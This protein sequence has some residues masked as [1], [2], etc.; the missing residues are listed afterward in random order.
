MQF[1]LIWLFE[2]VGFPVGF[3]GAVFSI[4][5]ASMLLNYISKLISEWMIKVINLKIK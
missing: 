5:L 3:V 4:M 2:K 1:V